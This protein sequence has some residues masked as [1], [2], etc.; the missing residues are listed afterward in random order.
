[1]HSYIIMSAQNRHMMYLTQ[2]LITKMTG[3]GQTNLIIFFVEIFLSI[4]NKNVKRY[5][6]MILFFANVIL[7]R[8]SRWDEEK[9]K[10]NVQ[11]NVFFFFFSFISC[12]FP[13]KHNMTLFPDP[14]LHSSHILDYAE[15]QMDNSIQDK[16]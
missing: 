11:P 16:L 10:K 4:N 5:K 8:R 2:N 7:V 1:M 9:K 3:S 6:S 14:I 12:Y 15:S 13:V